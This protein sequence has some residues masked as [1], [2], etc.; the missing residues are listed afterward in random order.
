MKKILERAISITT[1]STINV[2]AKEEIRL[3]KLQSG[4][5]TEASTPRTILEI[6][7]EIG[8]EH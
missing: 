4:K 3:V 5:T 7:V 1:T 8:I 6:S 2:E